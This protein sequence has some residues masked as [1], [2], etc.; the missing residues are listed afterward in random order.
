MP[1]RSQAADAQPEYFGL[2]STISDAT[3]R[4][5]EAYYH[6]MQAQ[7]ALRAGR[8]L[9]V[10]RQV[11]EATSLE[12]ESADLHAQSAGLLLQLG[13]R[14]EAER[15]A[16]RALEIDPDNRDSILVLADLWAAR[17]SGPDG[18]ADNR[19]EAIRLYERLAEHP[20][21][22]DEVLL[23][24]TQ[25][26]MR[27]GDS[28]GAI[29]AA[30]AL[31]AQRPGDP[32][33]VRLLSQ[34]MTVDGRFEEA[35]QVLLD[36]VVRNQ[37]AEDLLFMAEHLAERTGNWKPVEIATTR[38]IES[39]GEAAAVYSVR[40]RARLSLDTPHE[41]VLDLERA[42][43]MDPE[44]PSIGAD[45]AEA[46]HRANRL[47]DAA[48]LA[49]S[50]ARETPGSVRPL[51]ILAEVREGQGDVNGALSAYSAVLEV[52]SRSPGTT[53]RQRDRPRI[54]MLGLLADGDRMPEALQILEDLEEPSDPD[55]L[56]ITAQVSIQT[57]DLKRA[58]NV[59]RKLRS[60]GG[61]TV[62]IE[63]QVSLAEGEISKAM[64]LF[65]SGIAQLGP[66]GSRWAA[67]L[68]QEYGRV[69]EEESVLRGWVEQDPT[70]PFALYS[71]GSFLDRV[72][73]YDESEAR[74]RRALEL[75]P[76]F[77]EVMNYLGYSLADR[78]ERL[79]EALE[80]IRKAVEIDPWNG[81]YLDSLGW[82]Y[83]RMGRYHD[84]RAPLERAAKELPNDATVFDHLGDL[85]SRLQDPTAARAAWR[86][87][88][89]AAPENSEA[90]QRKL[91]AQG[92]VTPNRSGTPSATEQS[93]ARTHGSSPPDS[94]AR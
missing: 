67:R 80:L 36:F 13:Q 78:D 26:K 81:A 17:A 48:M 20:D 57:G 19:R 39:G 84:A 93:R 28:A 87:A 30:L 46:Y 51:W 74:F 32:L 3:A 73:R 77:A 47:A 45:L 54:R 79:N 29:D 71:L 38:I 62:L 85:Y 43:A 63:A 70:S 92:G 66:A 60:S 6:L 88:L 7:Q 76:Q 16:K 69:D 10:L 86:Q 83:F 27:D 8:V 42:I 75:R 52:L 65:A 56:R 89:G 1:V 9:E 94:S 68:L 33:P 91:D 44:D 49:H 34:A 64:E 25:L 22:D 50:V 15:I 5:G 14:S 35:Q 90:I 72:G 4:R 12:P 58:R 21:V 37:S 55:A 18:D 23:I 53:G 11:R 82:V 41:A 2:T 61:D 31:V 59:I 24:L 40:G